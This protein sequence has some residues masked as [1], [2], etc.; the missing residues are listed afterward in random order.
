VKINYV[1][2]TWTGKRRRGNE[3]HRYDK[4]LYLKEQLRL[5]EE[6]PH[7]L[8]RITVVAPHNKRE[9]ARDTEYLAG[10]DG[11]V[12]GGSPVVTIRR[13]NKGHSYG[14]YSHVFGLDRSLGAG[15]SS[16]FD[17]YIFME[18]DYAFVQDNFDQKMVNMFE[19][20]D[21]CGYLCSLVTDFEDRGHAAISN[22]IASSA[23]LEKVWEQ[24]GCLPSS[25][26]TTTY[27]C[28]SQ[29]QF[30]WAFLDAGYQL[31]DFTDQ[32][33]VLFNETG[34]CIR[35]GAQPQI[36]MAAIQFNTS[37]PKLFKL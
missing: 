14:S 27:H 2:A 10:L 15:K 7:D 33:S 36:M 6:Y 18:D 34:K 32:Y 37:Y 19:G 5:L 30:S 22:G 8:S 26:F 24:H 25:N 17:Y 21:N 11:T 1:I 9:L 3:A 31:H 29:L 35:F 4:T 28:Q 23:V 16:E 20:K 13:E 12:V